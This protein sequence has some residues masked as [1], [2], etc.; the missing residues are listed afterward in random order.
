MAGLV[1]KK[2]MSETVIR[3]SGGS[4]RASEI[5]GITQP[6]GDVIAIVTTSGRHYLAQ[7]GTHR[8]A[9][10]DLARMQDEF[11]AWGATQ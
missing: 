2:T 4:V 7:Y 6:F 8:E 5:E 10:A 3:F 11:D 9:D 1:G